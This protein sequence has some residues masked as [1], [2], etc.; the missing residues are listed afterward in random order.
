LGLAAQGYSVLEVVAALERVAGRELP[1]RIGPRRPGDPPALVAD[2]S[3]A[4]KMLGWKPQYDL[5]TIV[6]T[7]YDWMKAHPYG[8]EK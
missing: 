5:D 7:A 4:K 2:S 3:K 8:Y 6:K 1:K